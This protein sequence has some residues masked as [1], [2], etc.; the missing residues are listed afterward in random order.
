MLAMNLST[1]TSLVPSGPTNTSQGQPGTRDARLEIALF[2]L[3]TFSLT[4]VSTAVAFGAGV[5]VRH[6]EDASATGQAAMYAQAFWPAVGTLVAR[7]ATRGSNDRPA[8]GFRR[9]PLRTVIRCLGLSALL[10]T[11]PAI[12][13]WATGLGGFDATGPAV[14]LGL[15]QLPG[16]STLVVAVA[17]VVLPLPYVLLALGEDIGWRALLVTRLAQVTG[18]RRVVLVSGVAW[19]LFHLPLMLWLGGTP[20]G[21]PAWWSTAMFAT[22]I[23]AVSVPLAWMQLRW[24]IWPGVL[25]HA[26]MNATLYHLIEPATVDS[27]PT[28]WFATES[29]LAMAVIA[30][31]AAALWWRRAP[32]V[33]EVGGGVQAAL[34]YDQQPR[35]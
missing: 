28:E 12:L 19:A 29:G 15:E 23:V 13:V 6:I 33:R 26:V 32:L 22:G 35:T 27:G 18:P 16:G 11:A 34:R 17:L 1:A 24:G 2:L 9:V 10:T 3:V 14:A 25:A 5:D 20:D 30:V 8:L 31:A 21:A 7:L 4:A